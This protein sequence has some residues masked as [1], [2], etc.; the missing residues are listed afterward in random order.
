MDKHQIDLYNQALKDY[1]EAIQKLERIRNIAKYCLI[2]GRNCKRCK[3]Y[4]N[5]EMSGG[6][7]ILQIIDGVNQ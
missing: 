4:G 3:E 5:C 1:D 7:K 2:G 6:R